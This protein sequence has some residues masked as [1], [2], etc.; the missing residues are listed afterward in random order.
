MAQQDE[1]IERQPVQIKLQPH[2]FK[3]LKAVAGGQGRTNSEVV[4]AALIE[5]LPKQSIPSNVKQ[6][7]DAG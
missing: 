7:L 2:V 4:E 1:K 6:L 5:Y 3:A